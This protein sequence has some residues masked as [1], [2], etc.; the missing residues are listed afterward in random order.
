MVVPM[1]AVAA[2][3][4]QQWLWALPLCQVGS[5]SISD[6]FFLMEALQMESRAMEE[7]ING[8]STFHVPGVEI[9]R[10]DDQPGDRHVVS[11]NQNAPSTEGCVTGVVPDP[12]SP[13][14]DNVFEDDIVFS[15]EDLRKVDES[16]EKIR[17]SDQHMDAMFF[18]LRMFMKLGSGNGMK[19]T[20][21]DCNFDAKIR[22]IFD[23]FSK[24]LQCHFKT[25]FSDD[26]YSELSLKIF[27]GGP[28]NTTLR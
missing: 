5:G 4:R 10:D 23:K 3:E 9:V 24:D 14:N 21:T 17:F 27:I 28:F 13:T 26:K 6:F 8:S 22:D 19:A 1:D 15:E 16:T 20:S 7:Q 18:F 11:D 25:E 12:K 2:C